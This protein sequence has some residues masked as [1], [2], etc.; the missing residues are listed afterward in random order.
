MR[1]N[2]REQ[3]AAE[4]KW[5]EECGSFK[6]WFLDRADWLDAEWAISETK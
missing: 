2:G 6:T 3:E 1:W 5:I 4:S